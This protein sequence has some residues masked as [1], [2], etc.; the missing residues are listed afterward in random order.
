MFII[1]TL[2]L[3]KKILDLEY[4]IKKIKIS[5]DAS[6]FRIII[7]DSIK[8]MLSMIQLIKNKNDLFGKKLTSELLINVIS[9]LTTKQKKACQRVCVTWQKDIQKN[10]LLE[11]ILLSTKLKN[12]LYRRVICLEFVPQK[13]VKIKNYLYITNYHNACKFDTEKIR[14]VDDNNLKYYMRTLASNDNYMIYDGESSRLDIYSSNLEFKNCIFVEKICG[15]DIDHNNIIY[16]STNN[17]LNVY[18]IQGDPINSWDLVDN[19][20]KKYQYRNIAIDKDGIYIADYAFDCIRKFTF[21]GELI[22]SWELSSPRKIKIYKNYVFIID[23]E[24]SKIKVF[25]HN[26]RFVCEHYSLRRMYISDFVIINDL[27]Y[28]SCHN[29]IQIHRLIF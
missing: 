11:K 2:K 8:I 12:I 29:M 6:T 22:E 27:I 13:I 4:N 10:I 25:D 16:I 20:H 28:M 7:Y 15:V 3:E 24:N 21:Y 19:S 26:G 18:N 5:C 23:I 9:F 1:N 14:L 17:K